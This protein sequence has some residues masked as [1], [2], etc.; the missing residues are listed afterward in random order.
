[1]WCMRFEAKHK[2][3]LLE[4]SE[5]AKSLAKKHQM[6]VAYHWETFTLKQNQDG[7]IQSFSLRGENV[8][9]NETLEMIWSIDVFSTSWVKVDGVELDLLFAVRWKKTCQSFVK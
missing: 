5:T 9:N 2:L 8:V 7:P 1:M 3:I 4:I 6:A